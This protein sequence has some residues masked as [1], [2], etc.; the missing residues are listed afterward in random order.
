M[1]LDHALETLYNREKLTEKEVKELCER[2]SWSARMQRKID[3]TVFA[4]LYM[5]TIGCIF[6]SI[7]LF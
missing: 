3:S 2:V 7:S 4:L 6:S 5:T 1:N